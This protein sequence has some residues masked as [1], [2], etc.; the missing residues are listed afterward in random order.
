MLENTDAPNSLIEMIEY[1]DQDH[2][3]ADQTRIKADQVMRDHITTWRSLLTGDAVVEAYEDVSA[4]LD[5][6]GEHP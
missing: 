1:V 5:L 2:Y 4:E 6:P 3:L